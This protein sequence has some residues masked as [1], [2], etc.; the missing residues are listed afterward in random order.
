MDRLT[1]FNDAI[2]SIAITLLILP[3]VSDAQAI[4]GQTL[5]QFV[6]A[7]S[8][9]ILAFVISWL[10]IALLWRTQ[11]RILENVRGHT[12]RLSGEMFIWMFAIVFLPFPTE[13]ISVK[14]DT[15]GG[16]N[17]LYIGTILLASVAMALEQREISLTPALHGPDGPPLYDPVVNFTIVFVVAVAFVLALVAPQVGLWPL[18]LLFL[19]HP[20]QAWLG[21]RRGVS[22]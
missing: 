14:P 1:A 13:L 8:D 5:R 16:F 3:L 18:F 6:D 20:L 21:R 4:G 17:A 7:K 15:A 2:A 19:G 11:H 9:D 10:V 12:P 22:G